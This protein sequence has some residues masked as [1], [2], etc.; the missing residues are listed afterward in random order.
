MFLALERP[1]EDT[2]GK[3]LSLGKTGPNINLEEKRGEILEEREW[4]QPPSPFPLF[5]AQGTWLTS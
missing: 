2:P 1:E 5:L 4:R 3:A